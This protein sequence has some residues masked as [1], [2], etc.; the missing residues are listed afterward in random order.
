MG[1]SETPASGMRF[2]VGGFPGRGNTLSANEIVGLAREAENAGVDRFGVTDFPF[3]YD[4]IPLMTACL[5]ETSRLEVVSLVT[6]PFARLPDVTACTWATM[7]DMSRERAILGIGGGVEDPSRVWVPP[8]GNE[9]PHP[10]QAV[11]ELVAICRAMWSGVEPPRKGRVLN[12][13]GRTLDFLPKHPVPVFIAARGPMMLALAGEIAD[14]AHIGAPFLGRRYLRESIRRVESGAERANREPGSFELELTVI[15]AALGDAEKARRLVMPSVAASILWM[16]GAD[17]FALPNWERPDEFDI[18][19]TMVDALA[20]RWKM[21][22]GEPLPR[23]LQDL[24]TQDI[25][26]QFAV[27]GDPVRCGAQLHDL[28]EDFPE[29]TGIRFKLPPLTGPQ[30]RDDFSELIEG[31]G[32]AIRNFRLLNEE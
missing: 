21:W 30:S 9:R 23:E 18:P 7:S 27:V 29:V 5:G 14:I 13:S 17:D 31:A 19:E 15:L 24:F 11:R 16:A 1:T 12:S 3:Y 4:C 8:W 22:T 20:T 6:T 2:T 26:D 28:A 32:E 10:V 25:L